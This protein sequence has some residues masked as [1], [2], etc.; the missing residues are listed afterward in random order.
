METIGNP[1]KRRAKIF[2][3]IEL[4]GSNVGARPNSQ[5]VNLKGSDCILSSEAFLGR[6]L[7]Y[8]IF[9]LIGPN[10]TLFT[11]ICQRL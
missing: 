2:R 11:N 6:P 5:S 10:R 1:E 7:G 8:F 4:Q 9:F 3:H